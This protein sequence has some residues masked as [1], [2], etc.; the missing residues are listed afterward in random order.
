MVG[1][2]HLGDVMDFT[3][4]VFQNPYND[5]N[6]GEQEIWFNLGIASKDA[7]AQGHVR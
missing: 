4:R 6:A 5:T 7:L 1:M 3:A 2:H